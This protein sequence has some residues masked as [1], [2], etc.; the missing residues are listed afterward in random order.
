[1]GRIGTG[2]AAPSSGGA[3]GGPFLLWII[4]E[5]GP[6][7]E[8]GIINSA[9]IT[10]SAIA[11]KRIIEVEYQSADPTLAEFD[12]DHPESIAQN[13]NQETNG[14]PAK[15]R[16]TKCPVFAECSFG[17]CKEAVLIL[18]NLR[19]ESATCKTNYRRSC[20]IRITHG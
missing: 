20:R 5:A 7:P 16:S 8:A 18:G 11:N 19:A 1:V 2:H 3:G 12:N 6:A 9:H 13:T 17:L 14:T 4:P 15:A 10:N